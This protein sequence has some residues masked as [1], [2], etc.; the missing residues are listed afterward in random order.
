M[1]ITSFIYSINIA[2]FFGVD[3]R[4]KVHEH[5]YYARAGTKN[6]WRGFKNCLDCPLLPDK[7]HKA[8]TAHG[9]KLV[10][11]NRES[12]SALLV[13]FAVFACVIIKTSCGMLI[14]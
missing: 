6:Y 3:F 8:L 1:K 12:Y 5:D 4:C 14:H 9:K 2:G 13:N 10:S 7:F 11:L